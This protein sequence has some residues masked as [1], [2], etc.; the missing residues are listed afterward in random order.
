MKR[1]VIT[2]ITLLIV[3]SIAG[4]A[5]AASIPILVWPS[6]TTTSVTALKL[7]FGYVYPRPNPR[8]Y[9]NLIYFVDAGIDIAAPAD[10]QVYAAEAGTIKA[11][12]PDFIGL[13][14]TETVVIEHQDGNSNAYTTLYT[15]VDRVLLAV[16]TTVSARE[17]FAQVQNLGVATELHFGVRNAPYGNGSTARLRVLPTANYSGLPAFP[18][19]FIDPTT[20]LP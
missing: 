14:A 16:G 11:I 4:S 20:V 1:S 10:S 18:E 19:S 8:H 17:S 2:I 13:M 15:G 3:G 9:K 7:P 6:D 5:V 12:L